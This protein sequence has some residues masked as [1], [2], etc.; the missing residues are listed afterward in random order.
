MSSERAIIA[1]GLSKS[2]KLGTIR[3]A[4]GTFR[5]TVT[6]LGRTWSR[7]LAGEKLQKA[8][9]ETFWALKDVSFEVNR[10]EVL[11]VIGRNGAGKSTLLKVLS[12]ITAPTEGRAEIHGRVRSLLEVGTGFHP[13]LS[14]RENIYLNGSILGMKRAE[15]KKQFDAIVDFS[16]IERFLDTPVKR[17]SSGMYVRLAFSVAA[18]LE[19]EIL[20]IDEVLAVG[21][22]DFQKKCLGKMNEVAKGGRTVLFV[23][24]NMAAIHRQCD[25]VILL[26]QGRVIEDGPTEKT[27]GAYFRTNREEGKGSCEY[28]EESC[29][30]DEFVRLRAAS[31]SVG[32]EKITAYFRMDDE[33]DI[34]LDFDVLQKVDNFHMYIRLYNEDY[35]LVLGS[36]DWD[37]QGETVLDM[38]ME[39][40]AYKAVCRIPKHFLNKGSYTLGV[41]GMIPQHRYVF[42]E[43]NVLKFSVEERGGAGGSHSLTRPGVVRP[44]LDWQIGQRRTS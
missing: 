4:Y 22:A 23:S 8:E 30:G 33:I 32:K 15:V 34:E 21:D 6:D 25:R 16:G 11:G 28:E 43:A 35:T 5:D 19:P 36:G 18:H 38:S 2:Y 1:E 13:E 29:P 20:M 41:E 27:V 31:L 26:D 44:I 7:R 24:H 42:R 3:Q 10:G 37:G 17:Y 12:R 9:V 39:T 14:G 40:G